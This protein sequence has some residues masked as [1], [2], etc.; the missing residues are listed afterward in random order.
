MENFHSTSKWGYGQ[1][2]SLTSPHA[3]GATAERK[4]RGGRAA[5]Q[6]QVTSED[7]ILKW[8]WQ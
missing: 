3:S 4:A 7:Q 5:S 8:L 1:A 6:T 2:K